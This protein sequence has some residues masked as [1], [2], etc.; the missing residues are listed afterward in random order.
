MKRAALAS[1]LV[2]AWICAA[3]VH[4][5][6]AEIVRHCDGRYHM[7][8]TLADE[9]P[10]PSGLAWSFGDFAGAGHCGA[11]VGNRCRERARDKLRTCF[12]EHWKVRWDRVRPQACTEAAGVSRYALA[13]IKS[14]MEEQVC[15][16]EQ[17]LKHDEIVVN[18]YGITSGGEGCGGDASPRLLLTPEELKR[19]W[20]VQADY[21]M[22]CSEL[23]KQFCRQYVPKRTNP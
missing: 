12:T 7:L 11:T 2:T 8:A 17:A 6:A 3:A 19:S 9:R 15:C 22:D 5:G 18:L 14:I 10:A 16:S 13:D 1:G 4:A 20:L 21:K 23:R